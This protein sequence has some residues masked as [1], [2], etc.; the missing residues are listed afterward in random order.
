MSVRCYC[1]SKNH[2][3]SDLQTTDCARERTEHFIHV[4]RNN[5]NGEFLDLCLNKDN[6]KHQNKKSEEKSQTTQK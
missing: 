4:K 5:M 3:S 2:N 1:V 6:R